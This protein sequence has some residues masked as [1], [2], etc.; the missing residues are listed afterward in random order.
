MP[1]YYISVRG[2][3]GGEFVDE[4]DL[5]A[6]RYLKIPDGELPAP[7]HQI[8]RTQWV[9]EVIGLFR[10]VQGAPTGDI[11]FFV[12]GYNNTIA[13]VSQRQ[14]ALQAGLNQ[15]N[16][17]CLVISFDWPCDDKTLAYLND[18]DHAKLTAI[19]LVNGGV[20]LF[21][22]AL[23]EDCNI[24]VHVIGHSMGAYVIREAFDHADDGQAANVNW[25][26]NQLVLF[27]GDASAAKFS[28]T[29]TETESLYRHC[30]RLT[31]YYSGYDGALQISNVKRLGFAPRVG[32]VGL[33]DDA[34]QKAVNVD[35]SAHY[36]AT[37][38]EPGFD[39]P[40]THSWYY[41]DATFLRDLRLTLQGTI[42]RLKM[43]T[44]MQRPGRTQIL[45]G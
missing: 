23:R 45:L 1:Q 32:R 20:K 44:R 5:G 30:Y 2:V 34:P 14:N 3:S 36:V 39:I 29:N 31:N 4:I 6:V 41:G 43:P 9:A 13:A 38:G 40:Q 11:A 33:P 42:D 7:K 24:R 12:H 35:C 18:L 21:V 27:A 22:K 26:A 8:A 37:Y 16:F 15:D 10:K 28:A 17:S 25:T 19:R